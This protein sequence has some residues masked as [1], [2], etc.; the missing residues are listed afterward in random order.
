MKGIAKI[1]SVLFVL[2]V[3]VVGLSGCVILSLVAG[4]AAGVS[5]KNYY[6]S[7]NNPE[8]SLEV[9]LDIP[10]SKIVDIGVDRSRIMVLD[11]LR[12]MDEEIEISSEDLIKTKEKRI[13]QGDY[14]GKK[15]VLSTKTVFFN[16]VSSN[17][18]KITI[19]VKIFTD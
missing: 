12:E 1:L 4:V 3:F 7:Q 18:T 14:F 17:K 6:D 16:P 5:G 15:D 13:I 9:D 19:Q 11:C 2:F 8:E 10:E